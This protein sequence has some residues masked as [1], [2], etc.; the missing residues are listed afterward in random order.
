[1]GPLKYRVFGPFEMSVRMCI[2]DF[3]SHHQAQFFSTRD[4]V[5]H[6]VAVYRVRGAAHVLEFY[7]TVFYK[8]EQLIGVNNSRQHTQ[9]H[10]AH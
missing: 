1:M 2:S 6:M 3:V 5:L 4:G 8:F 10:R 9:S 7:L